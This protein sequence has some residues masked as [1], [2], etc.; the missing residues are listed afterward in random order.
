MKGWRTTSERSPSLHLVEL[1]SIEDE[2]GIDAVEVGA[3]SERQERLARRRAWGR[4]SREPKVREDAAGEARILDESQDVHGAAA[5]RADQHVDGKAPFQERGPL[6]PAG[7]CSVIGAGGV[8]AVY[9][10]RVMLLMLL[11]NAPAASTDMERPVKFLS[12][13]SIWRQRRRLLPREPE[14]ADEARRFDDGSL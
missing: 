9:N 1:A 10:G 14:A 2:R 4:T 6:E 8:A 5:A 12:A 3:G 11:R 13:I 7:A